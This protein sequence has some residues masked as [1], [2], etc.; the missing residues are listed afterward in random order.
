MAYKHACP[1]CGAKHSDGYNTPGTM[2]ETRCTRCR[3]TYMYGVVGPEVLFVA[4]FRCP[5]CNKRRHLGVSAEGSWWETK[6][7]RCRKFYHHGPFGRGQAAA[8]T[9]LGVEHLSG[10]RAHVQAQRIEGYALDLL[11]ASVCVTVIPPG[12]G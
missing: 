6:C 10:A 11:A 12:G 7:F 4:D 2:W 1:G 5:Y 8:V 3:M 9:T